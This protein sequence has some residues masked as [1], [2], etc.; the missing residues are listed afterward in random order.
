MIV[1]SSSYWHMDG[2]TTAVELNSKPCSVNSE[3]LFS[4]IEGVKKNIKIQALIESRNLKFS[5]AYLK[6]QKYIN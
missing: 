1:G 4:P 6:Y 2:N 5:N 3:L